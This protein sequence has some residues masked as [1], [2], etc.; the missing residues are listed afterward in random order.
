MPY[1]KFITFTGVDDRTNLNRLDRIARSYPVEW[2]ILFSPSNR[3]ARYPCTQAVEEMLSVAGGKAAHICGGFAKRAAKLDVDPYIPLARFDRTQING[4]IIPRDQ[5][6][7]LAQ[8]YGVEVILQSRED[9]FPDQDGR[10]TFLYDASG[11]TGVFPTRVPAHPGYFVGYAGGMGPE[12]VLD[13]LAMIEAE[14]GSFWIDMENR[15]RS[16]GWF[17]LDKVERVCELVFNRS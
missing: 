5:L 13:Y 4:K 14:D 10:S 2:G 16:N 1:P 15:V 3:D 9:V 7:Q 17:D 8:D 11:G 12:T 6:H